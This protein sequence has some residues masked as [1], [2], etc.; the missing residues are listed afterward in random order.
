MK[1]FRTQ[2]VWLL[3]SVLF[4][5]IFSIFGCISSNVTLSNAHGF[6]NLVL[7]KDTLWFGAGYKLYRADLN[8][9]I[10]TLVYDTKD[11]VISFVQIDG[12]RLYFG[13]YHSPSDN[14]SVIWSFDID[15]E[16]VLWKKEVT[17]NWGRGRIVI[18]PL[19]DKETIIFGTKTVLYGIDKTHG[20]NRWKIKDNWFG[21]GF[22]PILANGQLFYGIDNEYFGGDKTASG[23]T[24]AVVN[25]QSGT[26]I[27][28]ISMPGRLGATPII[29]GDCLFVK[30]YDYYK[31]DSTGKLQWI[32][33]LRL[34]CIDLNS[35]EI[36]WTFQGH[37]V[38]APSQISFY[39]G[40]VL[41]VFANQLYAIDEKFGTLHWQSP[42]L[43]A[44]VIN[45]QVIEG[46]NIIALE[47]PTSKKVIFL[48]STTGK[49]QDKALLNVLSSS[50]FIGQEAI[51]G[52]TNAIVRVDISTGNTIWSIP[53]DSQYQV[54]SGDE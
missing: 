52:T 16:N 40:R 9:H 29:H 28:T 30:D 20:I 25:P 32:G 7:D 45:P 33:A 46:L 54:S 48:D 50:T 36:I 3:L 4:V 35:G 12:K 22:T 42:S 41:D 37:G 15:D 17:D 51:Y 23:R 53:I 14:G 18:P 34:N 6:S 27:K 1:T 39:D 49:L 5:V 31:R 13:G 2:R 44:A 26:T 11:V 38:A 47:I 8:Q 21:T 19:I 24:I 43:E 10:A